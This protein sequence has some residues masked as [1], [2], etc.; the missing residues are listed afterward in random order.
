MKAACCL[1]LLLSLLAACDTGADSATLGKRGATC[2]F[3]EDC[4]T[5]TVCA[6][7]T[8]YEWTVCTG[9]VPEGGPCWDDLDCKFVRLDGLP[10][11]CVGFKCAF[12]T[13]I[14]IA[15]AP[16]DASGAATSDVEAPDGQ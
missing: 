14:P 2:E 6:K 16:A 8:E 7:T 10:L 3:Q 11:T 15:A 13:S 5:P 4:A 1:S 12:P 9:T